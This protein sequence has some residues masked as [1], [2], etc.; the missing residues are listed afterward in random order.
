VNAEQTTT[1]LGK[2]GQSSFLQQKS[3]SLNP[4]MRKNTKADGR[5]DK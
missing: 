1:L 4:V 2:K 3:R 5:S